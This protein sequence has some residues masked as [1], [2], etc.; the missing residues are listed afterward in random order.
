[1]HRTDAS[2]GVVFAGLCLLALGCG[3]GS[4]TSGPLDLGSGTLRLVVTGLPGATA[5]RVRLTTP[6]GTVTD[7]P[8]SVDLTG[9]P[10]GDYGLSAGYVNAAGQTWTPTLSSS[11]LTLVNHDTTE[12]VVTY[13]GGPATTLN[14]TIGHVQLLQSTQRSDGSIPMVAG[15]DVLLRA[16]VT[17]NAANAARPTLRV[18]LFQGSTPMDSILVPAPGNAVPTSVDTATIAASWNVVIPG[19]RVVAGAMIQLEVD[20][21]DLVPE[22]DK[23]NNRWPGGSTVSA[24]PVRAVA[25]YALRFVPVRISAN[26]TTGA[27]SNTNKD[28][29]AHTTHDM[30]PLG[31][32]AV[33]VR[34][35][36]TTSAAVLQSDDANNAWGQILSEVN[37]LR[38]SDNNTANYVGIVPV[39]YGGG[40]AGLGYIG[41]PAAIAWDKAS[42]APG[43]IAHEVGHNFGRRHAPCGSPASPDASYP[44]PSAAIVTWG[45]DMTALQLKAP[46]AVKDLMSY[47]NPTWVSDYTF[48]G[49][50]D[51]RDAHPASV[52]AGPAVEGLLVWGRIVN[53]NVVLEPAIPVTAPA[54][55]PDDGG[56]NKVEGFDRDGQRL[57]G[58][59]FSGELVADLPGGEE[60]HFAFVLP[61]TAAE[62]G[63]LTSIR[64]T[65][66]G[67]TAHRQPT[68]LL[69]AADSGGSPAVSAVNGV[70]RWDARFPM[71]VV[72]DQTSGEIIALG[73]GGVAT[74]TSDGRP[75]RI[76]LLDGVGSRRAV[77]APPSP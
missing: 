22:T 69:Q 7:Y 72:R 59:A 33:T 50:A 38:A 48:L 77:T 66:D 6:A 70:L 49:I 4:K 36:Y 53:G 16:F 14:L 44:Y 23:G 28:V 9:L 76:D 13:A 8:A 1:M 54:R 71:A 5:A 52:A 26:A 30:F 61:L 31:E 45:L 19:N 37:A 56:A 55:L 3:G 74:V 64:L 20:P 65:G 35:T 47:C 34:G 2:R 63:R 29:L 67:L 32:M 25:P 68:A 17:A 18:R 60:R 42:S 46:G 24:I 21:E 43:V 12:A 15:R 62:R 41:A 27:V 73:R 39:T 58:V 75:L 40:I 11:S 51:Y 10:A 57:F